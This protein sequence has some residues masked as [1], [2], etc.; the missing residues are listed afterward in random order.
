MKRWIVL[1]V[2]CWTVQ[3]NPSNVMHVIDGDTFKLY[4]FKVWPGIAATDE[5]V[6]LRT[7]SASEKSE[8]KGPDATAFVR[9]WLERGSFQV[10]ACR[11]DGL[12]RL[13]G[14][15]TRPGEPSLSDALK[16]AGFSK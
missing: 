4:P 13:L 2:L 6:R 1:A 11:R 15:V 8:T 14:E 10:K 7:T 16:A 12:G 9:A 3:L 5:R